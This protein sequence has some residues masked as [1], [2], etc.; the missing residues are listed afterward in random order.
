[1]RNIAT[2]LCTSAALLAS[3]EIIAAEPIRSGLQAGDEV[4]AIFEPLKVTGTHAGDQ[5]CL[6]CENGVRPVVMIFAREPSESLMKL[7][8]KIDAATAQNKAEEMGSFAV[9]LSDEENLPQQ[10]ERVATQH[11]LRQIVLSTYERAG[12]KGFHVAQ[13]AEVTV[14]MYR[15]FKVQA[16]HAFR[17][18]E[19]TDRAIE[20]IVADVPQILKK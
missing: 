5:R 20:K 19:L 7:L 3:V 17:K 14:V 6:V 12:P 18:G 9:F 8:A 16:N 13:D 2:I 4:T 11:A 15:E 10:L 1:M